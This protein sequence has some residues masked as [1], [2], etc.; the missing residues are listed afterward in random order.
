[1]RTKS[2][3]CFWFLA[4]LMIF[5]LPYSVRA[6]PTKPPHS[7]KLTEPTDQTA[8][9][10]GSI[11]DYS[12]PAKKAPSFQVV[13]DAL[14]KRDF[15][16]PAPDSKPFNAFH[17]CSMA[18]TFTGGNTHLLAAMRRQLR[19]PR[20]FRTDPPS[21][22]HS[23]PHAPVSIY[24]YLKPYEYDQPVF[25]RFLKTHH[26]PDLLPAKARSTN[27]YLGRL[28][29]P[30]NATDLRKTFGRR[31]SVHHG[32]LILYQDN[33]LNPLR[34]FGPTF[35]HHHEASSQFALIN[36][37][38]QGQKIAA[39]LLQAA[40][41]DRVMPATRIVLEY[42][43]VVQV[44]DHS[45][46]LG[47]HTIYDLW[48][49]HSIAGHKDLIAESLRQVRALI[50]NRNTPA[51]FAKYASNDL[52]TRLEKP[53]VQVSLAIAM[54][55]V[56]GT[57]T[58][59][60]YLEQEFML[61]SRN[62][63]SHTRGLFSPSGDPKWDKYTYDGGNSGQGAWMRTRISALHNLPAFQKGIGRQVAS[64]GVKFVNLTGDH[65][66]WTVSLHGRIDLTAY[67][68]IARREGFFPGQRGQYIDP[69]RFHGFSVPGSAVYDPKQRQTLKWVGI[70]YE[71]NGPYEIKVDIH[72]W[73]V[74]IEHVAGASSSRRTFG[75][76]L[77][78]SGR[79]AECRKPMRHRHFASGSTIGIRSDSR[80]H[81]RILGGRLFAWSAIR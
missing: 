16:L 19:K 6:Q 42:N 65:K 60:K 9:P 79:S 18:E 76:T 39:K 57:K 62:Y 69:N 23:D 22:F 34:W 55:P 54:P 73:D 53:W 3:Y 26:R 59:A 48:P 33:R 29:S 78:P 20:F 72:K 45:A 24:T 15:E 27:H 77:C 51:M 2:A 74:R 75:H 43:L 41:Q 81:L 80:Q 4:C 71:M 21:W 63:Q 56:R 50:A 1:M 30:V 66:H 49:N 46:E 5:S 44:T 14:R 38:P 61:L 37:T 12:F 31:V 35:A 40:Y 8:Y 25:L 11:L 64:P 7:T 17:F 36:V 10:A 47:E 58:K 70:M 32:N 67:Y 68:R 28:Q 13:V 52:K